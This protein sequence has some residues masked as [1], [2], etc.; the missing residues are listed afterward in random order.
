M[1]IE[2]TAFRR[3]LS[4]L[5]TG[6]TVLVAAEPGGGFVGMTAS[7]VTSLSLE[8][9]MVLACVGHAAAAHDALTGCGAFAVNVLAAGQEELSRRFADRARQRL[10]ADAE[11][12]TPSGLPR[13]PG[14]LA[15]LEVRRAAVHEAGDHSIVTGVVE[16]AWAGEGEPLLYLF[17]GYG[18]PAR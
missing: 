7:A 2:S 18:R 8:P 13:I 5:P 16:W 10:E 6:V 14:A 9:P 11:E 3:A 12:R 15:C 17:G 1:P 4:R